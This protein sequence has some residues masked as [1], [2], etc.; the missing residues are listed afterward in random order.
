MA[1][2][3]VVAVPSHTASICPSINLTVGML[4]DPVN[5]EVETSKTAR[6]AWHSGENKGNFS[7]TRE[8]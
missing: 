1:C 7:A 4:T 2:A 8:V 3:K 5:S 6:A